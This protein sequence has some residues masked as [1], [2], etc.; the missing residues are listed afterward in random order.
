MSSAEDKTLMYS[1]LR[2]TVKQIDG[3]PLEFDLHKEQSVQILQKII[4]NQPNQTIETKIKEEILNTHLNQ[5][6]PEDFLQQQLQIHEKFEQIERDK[7]SQQKKD[8]IF[9][10]QY[11]RNNNPI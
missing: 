6:L 3:Q 8:N 4:I 9:K 7:K 2:D 5:K 10:V 11:Q 1:T